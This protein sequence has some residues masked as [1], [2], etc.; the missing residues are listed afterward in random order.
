MS[1]RRQ[2]ERRNRVCPECG[3]HILIHDINY[4][5]DTDKVRCGRGPDADGKRC[6]W[7]IDRKRSEDMLLP[8]L[9]TAANGY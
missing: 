4:A 7:V 8:Q 2:K 5:E 9:N 6:G 1:D 3:Y